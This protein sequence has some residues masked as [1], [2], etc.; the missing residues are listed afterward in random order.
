MEK[1][2]FKKPELKNLKDIGNFLKKNLKSFRNKL[3]NTDFKSISNKLIIY[4]SILILLSS[5]GVGLVSL[6]RASSSLTKEAEKSLAS[7]SYEAAKTTS[8]RLETQLMMV[9]MIATRNEVKR[10]HW[11][12]QQSILRNQLVQTGLQELGVISPDGS[13]KYS[14][15]INEQLEDGDPLL[16]ALDGKENIISFSVNKSTNEQ[17]LLFATPIKDDNK[18]VGALLGRRNG[19]TLSNVSNDIEYGNDGY[20]YIIDNNGVVIA[21]RDTDKVINRYNPIEEAKN[22][23]SYNSSAKLFKKILSE[24]SG[25][26]EYTNDGIELYAGYA[27]IENTNWTMVI[28][29]SKSEVLS[30][31]PALRITNTIVTTIFLVLGIAVTYIIGKSITNPIVNAV[32]YSKVIG[33]LN[34]TKDIPEK[35][36]KMK[37]ETGQLSIAL[38]GLTNSLRGIVHNINQYSEQ[39]AAAS[40]ELTATSQQSAIAAEE[41]TKTVEEISKGASEQALNTELGTSKANL[42]GEIIE[43]NR[44]ITHTLTHASQNVSTVINDGL[45]EIEQLYKIT[46]ENNKASAEINDVILKTHESSSKIGQASDIIANIAD[47]T[48][49]LALNASIEAARAGEAGRGFAVVADEVRILAEQSLQSSKSISKIVKE[50]QQN[51]EDAVRTME[52]VSIIEKEQTQSVLNSQDKYRSI[53]KAMEDEIKAVIE[54]HDKGKEMESLKVEILD[55]LRNLSSI[56]EENSASTQEATASMEEQTASIEQI[57]GSSESLSN[58][59]Q[60]LQEIIKK[61]TI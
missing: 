22:D 46:L 27:P 57:A 38:Q 41:V 60:N 61:F 35:N 32:E 42:L 36:L 34:I 5:I 45:A 16:E 10:M 33:A 23:K 26:R 47:K 4:F 17:V 2:R 58:L 13:V 59:A 21:H 29:A 12:E 6:N 3:E 53:D 51:A 9:K 20:A 1:I 44:D 24:K 43:R 15:G 52:R 18:I 14:S 8:S 37:D 25:V 28:S 50:L 31:I 30:G 55:I 48:D 56:A 11:S 19:T 54:I 7:L 40:Q 49:L 39:L